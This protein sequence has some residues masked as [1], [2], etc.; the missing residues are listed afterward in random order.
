M[1]VVKLVRVYWL[2]PDI[3]DYDRVYWAISR[4]VGL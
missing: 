3:V 2:S 4:Y 1:I